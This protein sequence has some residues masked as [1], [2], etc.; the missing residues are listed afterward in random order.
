MTGPALLRRAATAFIAS[1]ILGAL[2]ASGLALP[3]TAAETHNLTVTVRNVTGTPLAGMSIMAIAVADGVE[4]AGDRLPN[5]SY[6][7]AKAVTGKPGVYTFTAL[8]DFDHTLYF[9]T[10][11]ST[12]FAQLLGGASDIARAQVI[13]SGQAS[14][15]V[16]LATNSVITGVVKTPAKKVIPK[17]VVTAYHYTGSD[18]IAYSSTRADAKGKYILR[19][20]DPG[21]YR[22]KFE[23]ASGN[24]SPLYS[25]GAATLAMASAINVGVGVTTTVNATFPTKVGSITGTSR[26]IYEDYEDYG[27]GTLAKAH[28][29]AIPVA[30]STV[31]PY[32]RI[33]DTE[34]SVSSGAADK[35][36]RWT[37]SNIVPGTYIVKVYPWYFNQSAIYAGGDRL[38]NARILTVT[39]G[40]K[41]TAPTTYAYQTSQGA[42]L[43]LT[44]V[45]SYNALPG[46]D[47]LVQ[48]D[49]DP[50][51]FYRGTTSASGVV[52]FGRS[53]SNHTMQPGAYTVTVTTQGA[54]APYT[55]PVKVLARTNTLSVQLQL[56]AK[57]AGFIAP[58]SI[59]ET[60]LTLGTRYVVAA[61][62]KRTTAALSY[63]WLRDGRP[64][65]G[66]DEAGY[67]SRAGDIGRQLSVRVSSYQFGYP[68]DTATAAVAGLVISEG[69]VPTVVKPPSM[70]PASDAHVGTVLR[71]NPGTWSVPGLSF[72]YRWFKDGLPFDNAGSAYVVTLADLG[73]VLTAEVDAS[74]T[75]HADATAAT[76]SGVTPEFAATVELRSGL[77]V[78]AAAVKKPK[79]TKKYTV[80]PGTWTAVAP[81]FRYEWM[82]GGVVVGTGTS[83]TEKPTAS[84]LAQTLEVRAIASAPGFGDGSTIA[85]ARKGTRALLLSVAPAVTVGAESTTV[86]A[87]SRVVVGQALAASG[88]TWIRSTDDVGV[89]RT[90]YQWLRK[91]G[92]AKV[93]AIAGATSATYV[94]KAGEVGAV[95]TVK[96]TATSSRWAAAS[97]TVAAGTVIGDGQLENLNGTLVLGGSAIVGQRLY[98][99]WRPEFIDPAIRVSYQWYGCAL[100]KCTATTPESGFT[101]IPK[102]TGGGFDITSAYKNGRLFLVQAL[103]KVG[104]RTVSVRSNTVTIAPVDVMSVTVRPQLLAPSSPEGSVKVGS[105]LT[106]TSG[107]WTHSIYDWTTT[108]QV[109]KADCL[110]EQAV[111]ATATGTQYSSAISPDFE[112]WGTGESYIRAYVEA[113]TATWQPPVLRASAYSDP[114]KLVKGSLS[115]VVQSSLTLSKVSGDTFEVS[116]GS[117]FPAFA[118]IA[119]RWFVDGV[120]KSTEATYTLSPEDAG[121]TLYAI[122]TASA[123]GY[124]SA[125]RIIRAPRPWVSPITTAPVTIIGSALGDTLTLSDPEPFRNLPQFEHAR[126]TYSYQWDNGLTY[127]G[128]GPTYVPNGSRVGKYVTVFIRASSP[129]F[130]SVLKTVTM[131]TPL[132]QGAPLAVTSASGLEWQGNLLPGTTVSTGELSFSEPTV[133]LARTWQTSVDGSTWLTEAG[134]TGATFTPGLIHADRMLRTI[135]TA[136]KVGHQAVVHTSPAV[137]ILEGDV[138]RALATPSLTGDPRVGSVLTTTS[139]SWS[140]GTAIQLEWLL[141]GRAIPG[142]TGA[143]YVPLATHAGDEISVRVTGRQAGKLDVVAESAA[144][145][146]RTGAA[147]TIVKAPVITGTTTLTATPGVWNVAGLTYGFEWL[148]YDAVIS[149]GETLVLQPGDTRAGLALR[150][151]ATR[152]G[153]ETGVVTR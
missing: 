8:G 90:S 47:V 25:G 108:W 4:I 67:I 144:L 95:L 83:F 19:D 43:S 14:I 13:P 135:V 106:A 137:H 84:L 99:D 17:A 107:W 57:P 46:A 100:P 51:Y 87:S 98:T 82:R 30:T 59:A 23:G 97:T 119:A 125:E 34:R 89:M 73:S 28:A 76:A 29:V 91:V 110:N 123:V 93:A 149:T 78:T 20:L 81:A 80:K 146:I 55:A 147:P 37:I 79:G 143:T 88:G 26:V 148:R 150:V 27:Y 131:T 66:A 129:L 153:Y 132:Q 36:G 103:S 2:L 53:G 9:A 105:Y 122:L 22:L 109:C 52:T 74:K 58:P 96:V 40:K 138:V 54:Y 15:S 1:T 41:V 92:K 38:E 133:T 3:A 118:T 72:S 44:V 33:L 126:W 31:Y 42:S 104:S 124:D 45:A 111:W 152:F 7:T 102:A 114:L 32:T 115:D 120:E 6:P 86:G 62:A 70:S 130:G 21:S 61:Q 48:S 136:T 139:G 63:Q 24:L 94:P 113:N 151:T 69:S 142:A 18:W 134:V 112:N 85:V 121:G 64:I 10:P 49:S 101:K 141:N 65:Y 60:A 140:E 68:V 127:Y 5:G 50:D 39:A 71:V 56:P 12:T 75:G 128:N 117:N 35:K 116:R 11:T 77:M 145:T 16:S